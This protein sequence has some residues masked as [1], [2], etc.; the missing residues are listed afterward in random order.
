MTIK[1]EISQTE[2]QENEAGEIEYVTDIHAYLPSHMKEQVNNGMMVRIGRVETTVSYIGVRE[3]DT[4]FLLIHSDRDYLP[5]PDGEY[6]AELVL[7]STTT[8][9]FLWS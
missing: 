6:D 9:S 5:L 8:I 2:L 1:V 4:I 3:D 7:E